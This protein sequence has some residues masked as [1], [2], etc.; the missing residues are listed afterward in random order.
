MKYN[1]SLII[2]RKMYNTFRIPNPK[3]ILLINVFVN[4]NIVDFKN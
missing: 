1:D 3:N 2:C 4:N